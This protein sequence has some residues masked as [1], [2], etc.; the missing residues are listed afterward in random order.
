MLCSIG[1]LD[2][3]SL[4]W[5]FVEYHGNAIKHLTPAADG[6][7]TIACGQNEGAYS[8]RLLDWK[9]ADM[10]DELK[11]RYKRV[12]APCHAN[13]ITTLKLPIR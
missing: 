10:T 2:V 1:L 13:L 11:R 6:N 8:R 4:I 9:L 7:L 12:N 5:R 3:R